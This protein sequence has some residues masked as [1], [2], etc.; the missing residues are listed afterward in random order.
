MK[1]NTVNKNKCLC[2]IETI[3]LILFSSVSMS[4]GY[5]I[6]KPKYCEYIFMASTTY[7]I[8]GHFF[9]L[10]VDNCLKNG[11]FIFPQ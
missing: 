5:F 10:I 2:W 3:W 6:Q 9:K 8:V 4:M 11:F 1:I 7:K